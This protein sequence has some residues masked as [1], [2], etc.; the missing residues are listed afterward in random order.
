MDET[1]IDERTESF[2]LEL[3]G[4]IFMNQKDKDG[5]SLIRKELDG[6]AILRIVVAILQDATASNFLDE[7]E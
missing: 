5:N 2:E 7:L 4:K 3:E 6:E 1:A